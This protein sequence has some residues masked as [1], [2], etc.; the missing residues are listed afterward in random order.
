MFNRFLKR[1]GFVRAV[2]VR[3]QLNFARSIGKRLDEHREVVEGIEDA[4]AFFAQFPW[5]AGHMAIQD[6]F[7]MRLYFL[8]HGS[9]PEDVPIDDRGGWYQVSG[10]IV[11]PRPAVL[12][13]CRLP[14][15]IAHSKSTSSR[16]RRLVGSH[17]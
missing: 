6:D 2:Y 11:R 1:L 9:W 12:G 3:N 14:E 16:K 7:L 4:T 13:P 17:A 15:Y 10:E 5:H 8:V